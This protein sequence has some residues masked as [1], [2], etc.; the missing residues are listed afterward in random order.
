M[1]TNKLF[2]VLVGLLLLVSALQLTSACQENRYNDL[3]T[4][5]DVIFIIRNVGEDS[6]GSTYWENEDRYP[7]YDYRNGYSFRA[8]QEYQED[9]ND[10][11]YRNTY[12]EDRFDLGYNYIQPRSQSRPVY[13]FQD[14]PQYYY[15]YDDYM[16]SYSKHECY[17]R[18]PSDKLIYSKCP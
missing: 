11:I 17:T 15:T 6:Y 16:R 9:L 12:V 1:K 13:D 2:M 3:N 10:R 18:S 5:D 14:E 4:N 7:T 8:T